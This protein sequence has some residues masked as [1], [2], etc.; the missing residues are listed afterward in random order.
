EAGG[1]GPVGED[2]ERAG[3]LKGTDDVNRGLRA[4]PLVFPVAVTEVDAVVGANTSRLSHGGACDQGHE[5]EE[6]CDRKTVA[7]RSLRAHRPN[8][9]RLSCGALKKNSFLNLRAPPA[10]SAC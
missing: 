2:A 1:S 8:G 10:S 7:H 4:E 3:G 9:P 5:T 6:K